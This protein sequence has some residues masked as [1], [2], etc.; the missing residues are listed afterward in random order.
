LVKTAIVIKGF[1]SPQSFLIAET[2]EGVDVFESTDKNDSWI[3]KFYG[4]RKSDSNK[5][6][7]LLDGQTIEFICATE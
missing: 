2:V 7:L 5:A 4:D 1:C 6:E 3:A